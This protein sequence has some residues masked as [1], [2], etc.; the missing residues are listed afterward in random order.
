MLY[1][2]FSLLCD[3]TSSRSK[4]RNCCRMRHVCGFQRI[5]VC[6]H[7]L[8]SLFL[9]RYSPIDSQLT[10]ARGE[11]NG[12]AKRSRKSFTSQSAMAAPRSNI[13]SDSSCTW[14]AIAAVDH[15]SSDA[16]HCTSVFNRAARNDEAKKKKPPAAKEE[17]NIGR[18]AIEKPSS[19]SI[20]M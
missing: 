8:L 15:R 9:H 5:R 3:S 10:E 4:V 19:T 14:S 18:H 6:I 17:E 13:L 11:E 12:E 20:F 2:V 7:L 16:S 1:S